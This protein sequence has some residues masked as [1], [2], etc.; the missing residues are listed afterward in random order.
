MGFDHFFLMIFLIQ[1]RSKIRK[2][3]LRNQDKERDKHNNR[4]G[5]HWST[6]PMILPSLAL[7]MVRSR[8]LCRVLRSKGEAGWRR[9]QVL[10][11]LCWGV[12]W[13]PF[14]KRLKKKLRFL[15]WQWMFVLFFNLLTL[16]CNFLPQLLQ[17]PLKSPM[18]T[19]L[20]LV[21]LSFHLLLLFKNNSFLRFVTVLL[22][23]MYF[24]CYIYF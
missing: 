24:V 21:S 8:H 20:P 19:T 22:K 14:C 17:T 1:G 3:M 13:R 18:F 2:R 15:N 5:V 16:Q 10:V 23:V 11:R 6:Y 7:R 4:I 12:K 9:L